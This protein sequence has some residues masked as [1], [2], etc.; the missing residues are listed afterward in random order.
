M[1]KIGVVGEG[2]YNSKI[3]SLTS[4]ELFTVDFFVHQSNVTDF[5]LKSDII[6]I[7]NANN[8]FKHADMAVRNGKHIFIEN[9]ANFTAQEVEELIKTCKEGSIQSSIHFQE[10]RNPA[11]ES[12]KE[13]IKTPLFIES[14]R[15][16]TLKNVRCENDVVFE[17]MM[18][19]IFIVLSI[20]K[21]EIKRISATGIKVISDYKDIANARLEFTNGCIANFT[22]SR[23][24]L[25]EMNKM[26][27]FQKD[28]YYSV[29]FFN[30]K[31]DLISLQNQ[32]EARK[33]L[34]VMSTTFNEKNILQI[35]INDFVNSIHLKQHP[36]VSME[37]GYKSLEVA[38]K[39]L[40]KIN[41][42][43]EE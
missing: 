26:R 13:N 21:S 25:K 41:S 39:I 2:E 33:E 4:N 23:I 40:K 27:I 5:I 35:E 29:D 1:Y 18:Q 36:K 38:N 43:G 17:L 30:Q 20:V 11:I 3:S 16:S 22:A 14:H 31:T 15:L 32:T 19:D 7:T 42:F 8:A 28:S 10:N 12:I 24:S 34:Q 37:D 9:I 6:L